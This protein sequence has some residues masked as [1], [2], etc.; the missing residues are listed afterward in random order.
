MTDLFRRGCVTFTMGIISWF[1][2]SDYPDTA[3]FLTKEE[4]Q[5]VCTALRADRAQL[6]NEPKNWPMFW[7]GVKDPRTYLWFLMFLSTVLPVYSILLSLPSVVIGLGYAGKQAVLMA[8]PPYAVGFVL[9]I[10]SGYTSDRYRERFFH[11]VFGCVMS[12]IALITLMTVENLHV[13]YGMYF[14]QMCMFIPVNMIW[15]WS[16]NNIAG[17]NK[18]AASQAIMYCGANVG[19]AISGQ[20]YRAEWGPRYVKSHG[21]ICACYAVAMAAGTTL[22]L[23]YRNENRRRDREGPVRKPGDMLGTDLGILGDRHPDFRYFL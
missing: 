20:I 16:A 8:C 13:R 2:L 10:I 15:A 18:R 4:Q 6:P 21:I 9:V 12:M 14:L 3:W 7:T 5:L 19:G 22:Y 1:M 11:L 23:T 17:S